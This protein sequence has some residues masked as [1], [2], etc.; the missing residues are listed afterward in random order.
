MQCHHRA[1]V[2]LQLFPGDTLQGALMVLAHSPV[3]TVL[4]DSVFYQL[5]APALAVINSTVCLNNTQ[6]EA[7]VDVCFL[8]NQHAPDEV[9]HHRILTLRIVGTCVRMVVTFV[10]TWHRPTR[11][12]AAGGC[13]C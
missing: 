9:A 5:P 6:V 12:L 2:R 13:W 3:E 1:G 7:P 10:M 4:Q 8:R 11:S